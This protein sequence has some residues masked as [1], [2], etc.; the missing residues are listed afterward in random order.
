MDNTLTVVS[1]II[2]AIGTIGINAMIFS[3]FLGKRNQKIDDH[4]KRIKSI[5]KDN[6]SIAEIK[7]SIAR[8]E[9]GVKA[10]RENP[11]FV[12]G[13]IN[14]LIAVCQDWKPQLEQIRTNT[15]KIQILETEMKM[16]LGNSSK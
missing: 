16:H 10:I 14:T 8:V 15:G 1:V 2:A 6:T 7:T 12:D 9:E 11:I 4:E 13:T 3:Y 5:E